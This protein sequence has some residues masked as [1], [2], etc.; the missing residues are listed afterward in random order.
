[1]TKVL[2]RESI[3]ALSGQYPLKSEL[4]VKAREIGICITWSSEWEEYRVTLWKNRLIAE[5]GY[6]T[7]SLEDA[8]NTACCMAADNL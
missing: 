1:M 3:L 5:C 7:S 8:W 4:T 2:T 6:F